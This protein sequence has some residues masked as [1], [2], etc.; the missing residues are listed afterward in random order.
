VRAIDFVGKYFKCRGPLNTVRSPQGRPTF[1]QAGGSP[2]G[3]DFAAKHADSII[4]VANGV[5]G[6]KAYRDDVRARME[7]HG[8]NPDNCKVLFV[9]GPILGETEAE[10]R[11]KQARLND[12]PHFIEMALA[13]ISSVT[14]ID[15]SQFELD[16]PL[17]ELETNGERG[18]LDKFAQ[19]GSGKTLRQLIFDAGGVADSIELVGTPDQVAE[20]MGQ[21][22]EEVGGDGF[23]MTA[24]GM[25]VSRRYISE[26]TD[27]LIPA[28]Q[29]RGLTRTAYTHEHLRD[30]LRDF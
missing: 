9:I 28:L 11:E 26:I 19:W 20:Q 4:A 30:N 21:V 5:E 3:R 2:K 18:S 6:M 13:G 8:R 1:V 27:G 15:F 10:A 16:E 22:M 23:L 12:S 25:R 7:R 14:D 29:R 17:P 24:P